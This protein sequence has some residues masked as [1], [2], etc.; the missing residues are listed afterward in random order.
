MELTKEFTNGFSTE[1]ISTKNLCSGMYEFWFVLRTRNGKTLQHV[2]P[3]YSK[4]PS[5]TKETIEAGGF[6]YLSHF[7]TRQQELL[8]EQQNSTSR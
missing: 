6:K 7:E 3:F 8:A 5:C 4:S 2:K 1:F